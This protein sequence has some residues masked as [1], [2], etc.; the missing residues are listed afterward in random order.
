[1]PKQYVKTFV[2]SSNVRKIEYDPGTKALVVTFTNGSRYKYLDVPESVFDE[3][4]AAKSIGTFIHQN[5][6]SV[7]QFEKL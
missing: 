5:V 7:Y 6:K 3:A 4:S 2:L 1:M